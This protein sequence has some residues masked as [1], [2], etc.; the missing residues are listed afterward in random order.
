LRNKGTK[1]FRKVDSNAQLRIKKKIGEVAENLERYKHLHFDFKGSC[2]IRVG[3]LR[4]L[5]SYNVEKQEL[6][7]EQIIF[8][9]RY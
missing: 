1:D 6:Y 2:R 5:F 9:H 8:R 4:I 3:K 7:L